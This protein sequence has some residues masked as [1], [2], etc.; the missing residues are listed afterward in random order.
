M[1]IQLCP[2]CQ[3]RV[4]PNSAGACPSCHSIFPTAIP[5]TNP[6]SDQIPGNGSSPVAHD[7]LNPYASSTIVETNRPPT[8]PLIVPA[9]FLLVGSIIWLLMVVWV[10]GIKVFGGDLLDRLPREEAVGELVGYI[11]MTLL[12]A[13]TIV[14]AGSM[15]T[16]QSRRSAFAGTIVALIPACGPCY[17]LLFPFAIWAIVVM[18][19]SDVRDQ[20]KS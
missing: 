4:I 3:M 2:K 11:L 17:G 7:A 19:R 9:L 8:D 16:R 15:L 20:F 5:A 14:G 13:A 10:A 18:R 1:N 6:F 12:P